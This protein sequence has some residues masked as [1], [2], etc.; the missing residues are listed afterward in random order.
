VLHRP[1]VGGDAHER[2]CG[3]LLDRRDLGV[4]EDRHQDARALL[5]REVDD[6]ST[7]RHP[8]CTKPEP[9]GARRRTV[10]VVGR[11]LVSS[12]IAPGVG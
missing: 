2:L 3:A 7:D 6:A 5:V 8:R 11:H 9:P 1:S 10:V 4:T 12:S